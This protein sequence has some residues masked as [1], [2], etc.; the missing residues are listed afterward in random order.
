MQDDPRGKGKMI[1]S[2]VEAQHFIIC[3]IT[4]LSP[5]ESYQIIKRVEAFAKRGQ[6]EP[7]QFSRYMHLCVRMGSELR[8]NPKRYASLQAVCKTVLARQ[9]KGKEQQIQKKDYQEALGLNNMQRY[10]I[11]KGEAIPRMENIEKI[12]AGF[13]DEITR[14]FWK[15]QFLDLYPGLASIGSAKDIEYQC[16]RLVCQ[17]LERRQYENIKTRLQEAE[18]LRI[19]LFWEEESKQDDRDMDQKGADGLY[20]VVKQQASKQKVTIQEAAEEIGVSMNTWF[21]WKHTWDCAEKEGFQKIPQ[22]RLKRIHIMILAAFFEMG[23]LEAV[24][25]MA[26]A[27][28]RFVPGEPDDRAIRYFKDRDTTSE[29]IRKYLK[30]GMFRGEW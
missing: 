19:E 4:G 13:Q 6:M 14:R 2:T 8:K 29:E 15:N 12:C 17:A 25:L 20:G 11:E 30:D 7:K 16:L 23:Y 3:M 10:R 18:R 9:R 27:G 5:D 24:M 1:I 26:L 22:P 21:K 28:Y